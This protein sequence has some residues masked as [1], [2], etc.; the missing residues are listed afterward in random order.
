MSFAEW[1]NN[2]QRKTD[3]NNN[4]VIIEK[5]N[6][7]GKKLLITGK[8]RCNITNNADTEKIFKILIKEFVSKSLSSFAIILYIFFILIQFLFVSFL[9]FMI[10][11]FCINKP[12]IISGYA[13]I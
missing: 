6:K 8:G 4:S 11:S 9:F 13:A 1:S 7:P 3:Y 2:K 12:H 5:N 10:V